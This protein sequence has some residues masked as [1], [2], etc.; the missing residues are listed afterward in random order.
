MN[1]KRMSRRTYTFIAAIIKAQ[2]KVKIIDLIRYRFR[3][4]GE[5][6][7]EQGYSSG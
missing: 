2:I 1:I 5:L 3:V 7:A 4:H 6:P